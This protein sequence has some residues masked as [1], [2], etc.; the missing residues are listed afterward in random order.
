LAGLK[1]VGGEINVFSRLPGVF[2]RF[3]EL[4]FQCGS[5]A[6]GKIGALL[7]E[8]GFFFG[9]LELSFERVPLDVLLSLL[10]PALRESSN[11]RSGRENS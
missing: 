11:P 8:L 6:G 9:F 7:G 2:L 5:L 10:M 1:F 3:L 4:S